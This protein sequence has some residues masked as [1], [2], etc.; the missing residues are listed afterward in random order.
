VVEW[1]LPSAASAEV[2]A[3]EAEQGRRPM[4][5]WAL[6]GSAQSQGLPGGEKP[7]SFTAQYGEL[8]E[9]H[10]PVWPPSYT[11]GLLQQ[12]CDFA[13]GQQSQR[14]SILSKFNSNICSAFVH[15]STCTQNQVPVPSLL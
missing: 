12:P 10:L 9:L 2:A 1:P 3:P 14:G 7:R 5:G 15:S 13:R 11:T 8:G 4:A 6:C